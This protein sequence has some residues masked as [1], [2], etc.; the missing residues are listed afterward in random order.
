M[1]IYVHVPF[2]RSKCFYCG[3]Y[4]VASPAWVDAYTEALC[5]EIEMRKDY[6]PAPEIFS[7]YFGG[8]TPSLLKP[9]ALERIVEKLEK[10]YQIAPRAE[11]TIEINPEDGSLEKLTIFRQL[12]FNRISIGIQSLEDSIL[13]QIR[14]RHS[15]EQALESVEQAVA[16]GF[17]NI[18]VDLIVGFPGMGLEGLEKSLFRLKGLPL[19]HVSVYMLSIDPSSILEREIRRGRFVP[20]SDDVVAE[21]FGFLVEGL[22]SLGFEH[23]EISNFARGGCYS[24]HNTAYWQQKPYIGFGPSAHSYDG[25]S[26]QWNISQLKDYIDSLNKW[27]LNFDREELSQKDKYNEYIMTRLRTKWGIDLNFLEDHYTDFWKEVAF[28]LRIYREEGWAEIRD[29]NMRLTEKGWLLSDRI[30]SDLFVV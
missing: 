22:S 25:N 4:S 12:G 23:Y 20:E 28:Q 19:T 2:C 13:K 5:R 16:A 27:N 3:F 9:E 30:F 29:A 8:G 10:N 15:A 14:R 18:G 17:T 11:R 1:G 7:L 21:E 6:L 26:R 24:V